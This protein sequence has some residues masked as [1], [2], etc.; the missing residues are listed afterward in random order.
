M[1]KWRFR[2][3]FKYDVGIHS[4]LLSTAAPREFEYVNKF[5]TLQSE[6][7]HH[8]HE[9]Q[10]CLPK[11]IVKTLTALWISVQFF[12]ILVF[13]S[14]CFIVE[15][16]GCA[17]LKV[18]REISLGCLWQPKIVKSYKKYFTKL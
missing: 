5:N 12:L 2:R 9:I 3:A 8:H 16:E 15:G 1:E 10:E 14:A 7:I 11:A 6:S 13:S 17:I 4:H 18:L